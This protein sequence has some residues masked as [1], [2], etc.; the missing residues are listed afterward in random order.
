M[1]HSVEHYR[2]LG[3]LVAKAKEIET[4]MLYANYLDMLTEALKPRCT[5]QKHVNVLQH[6]IGYFKKLITSAEKQE[7]L[8]LIEQYKIEHIPLIVP[9]TL[10]NHYVRKYNQKYL[11]EQ[12][13]LHPHPIELKL[14][15]H[16]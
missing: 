10:I 11:R 15:N 6:M 8:K 13:Y 9:V 4:K 7:L 16:A 5:I 14:R 12:F 3:R 2:T 1:A